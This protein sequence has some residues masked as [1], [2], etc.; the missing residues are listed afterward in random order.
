MYLS[1]SKIPFTGEVFK[2]YETNEILFKGIYEDGLLI[3]FKYFELDGGIK[4]SIEKK[5]LIERDGVVFGPNGQKEYTGH[6]F[7]KTDS[8]LTM[9]GFY[10]EGKKDRFWEYWF[11]NGSKEKD[12]LYKEGLMFGNW[13]FFY[14]NGKIE[15]NGMYL[16]GDGKNLGNSG[17]PINGR[18]GEWTFYH[19]N[20]QISQSNIFKNGRREGKYNNWY[21]N[22]QK[23]FEGFFSNDTIDGKFTEWYENGQKKVEGNFLDKKLDGKNIEW[24]ENGQ[25]M[26]EVTFKEDNL[27][28]NFKS[29]YE[30]GQLNIR[31][32]FKNGQI[33]GISTHWDEQGD[34]I[35]EGNFSISNNG[36]VTFKNK[37]NKLSPTYE[38]STTK[39]TT[40]KNLDSFDDFVETIF[41]NGDKMEYTMKNGSMDGPFTFRYGSGDTETGNF[42]NGKIEGIVTKKDVRTGKITKIRYKNGEIIK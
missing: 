42:V 1:D 16:F 36:L 38:G 13:R 32:S 10:L 12:G 26:N 37:I 18:E 9:N 15:V 17:I 30:N 27:N 23:E 4:E 24:Y 39:G 40:L 21:E 19:K 11:P 20:G 2:K 8:V 33:E 5:N 22:G 35:W 14:E 28:G 3:E 34:K 41:S 29:W 25:K 7:E 31:S 6:T